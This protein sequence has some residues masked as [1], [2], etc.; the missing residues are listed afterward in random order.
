[1]VP[2]QARAHG[3]GA[4]RRSAAQAREARNI[5]SPCSS[6]IFRALLTVSVIAASRD[7]EV[8]ARMKWTSFSSPPTTLRICPSVDHP[9]PA[10]RG[11]CDD[12]EAFVLHRLG[13]LGLAAAA[14]SEYALQK[15]EH[16]FPPRF[17]ARRELRARVIV[18]QAVRQVRGLRK[19]WLPPYQSSP[20][21]RRLR[22]TSSTCSLSV[23]K[24]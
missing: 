24:S 13:R 7:V 17:A 22:L 15:S 21:D 4:V 12:G 23:Q 20:C 8:S 10:L 18:I 6:M 19:A 16:C 14:A 2:R 5:R 1:M 9:L 3:Q 11:G